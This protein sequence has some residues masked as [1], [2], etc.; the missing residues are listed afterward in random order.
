MEA[1]L[2]MYSFHLC[3]GKKKS[4]SATFVEM[5]IH[6]DLKKNHYLLG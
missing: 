3:R 1:Q 5:N 4:L 6:P 2:N